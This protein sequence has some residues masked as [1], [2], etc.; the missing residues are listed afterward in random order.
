M[1][2]DRTPPIKLLRDGVNSRA[3]NIPSG[4]NKASIDA[5]IAYS[6]V[7]QLPQQPSN[8]KVNLDER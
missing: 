2:V 8:S 4:D 5:E 6:E 3:Q 1:P 7:V